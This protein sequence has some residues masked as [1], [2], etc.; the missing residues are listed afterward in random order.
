VEDP[1]AKLADAITSGWV[2]MHP[3]HMDEVGVGSIKPAGSSK[4]NQD[5]EKCTAPLI[6]F[7]AMNDINAVRPINQGHDPFFPAS[8][9]SIAAPGE[10]CGDTA[11]NIFQSCSKYDSW[12]S[13]DDISKKRG[14]SAFAVFAS[15]T[16]HPKMTDVEQGALGTCYFLSAI[17]SIAYRTPEII[18]NMF[19]RREYW[20]QGILST[21]W[22]INGIESIIEVDKTLP[23][24]DGQPYFTD[25]SPAGAWW[26]AILEKSWS[27]IYGSYKA[28]E[29][30]W[31]AI[32][33]GSITRAPTV[34]YYHSQVKGE[35][36]WQVLFDASEKKWP[37]G[38]STTES[39]FGLAAGHAYSLLEAWN[40][41]T[42]GKVVKVR[43]PWHINFYEG[44]IPNPTRGDDSGIF[45]M[46]F[47]EFEIAFYSSSVAKVHPNYKV[48]PVRVKQV[49]EVIEAEFS[50]NIRS[51][52]WFAVSLVWPNHRMLCE[53]AN[54][55]YVLAMR[56]L[57]SDKVYKPEK[58]AYA[59][60]SVYVE[61][62]PDADGGHGTYIVAMSITFPVDSFIK[63][64]FLNV[65]AETKVTV[66]TTHVDYSSLVL[67]MVGPAIK[68]APCEVVMMKDKGLWRANKKALLHGVPT[69]DSLDGQKFAYYVGDKDKWYLMTN[70]HW[71]EVSKGSL[72]SYA[73]VSTDDISCGC[74]DSAN[75]VV[76]LGKVSCDM[77]LPPKVRYGNLRCDKKVQYTDL[78]K[79]YCPETCDVDICKLPLP[80]GLDLAPPEDPYPWS[81]NDDEIEEKVDDLVPVCEDT[82]KFVDEMG[83]R[84]WEWEGYNCGNAVERWRYTD[85][86]EIE[87]LR[88]CKA[89][90]GMCLPQ[91][92][93]KVSRL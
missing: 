57:G 33:A 45:T 67:G 38:A 65:Y 35:Q 85:M 83:L 42:H 75:G 20:D 24:K 36:L 48:T 34:T 32:A 68:G 17:S 9:G 28:A 90:C 50:F 66:S 2:N 4:P 81:N 72:W 53:I 71:T 27:K 13:M 84:C 78:A 86:G 55:S 18:E 79:A 40:D 74:E 93:E 56:K 6:R 52:K 46:S 12:E 3:E 69:Y 54:P 21:R 25:I 5:L 89:S 82:P 76:E 92:E 31:W 49:S 14:F 70:S 30:G 1:F 80:T 39:H 58:A 62:P 91:G 60:N 7:A 10:N 44:S 64:V 87:V 22:L 63:E 19:V 29:A 37:M 41:K 51:D 8:A 26:P 77:V 16:S 59:K 23:S 15:S 88:N 61:V 73:S 43:N 47:E 11:H